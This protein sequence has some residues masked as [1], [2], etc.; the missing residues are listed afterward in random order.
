MTQEFCG[1]L[2]G[3]VDGG[4]C[5]EG[6]DPGLRG[7]LFC[8]QIRMKIKHFILNKKQQGPKVM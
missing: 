7:A 2:L 6:A 1:F 8:L 5:G 3:L 4:H